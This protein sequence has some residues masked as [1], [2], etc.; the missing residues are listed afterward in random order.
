M[1]IYNEYDDD[2]DD[3]IPL[4]HKKPNTHQTEWDDESDEQLYCSFSVCGF[5]SAGVFLLIVESV[6]L[7]TPNDTKT[8]KK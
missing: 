7:D 8:N 2:E 5:G 6:E 1:N 3:A 4:I